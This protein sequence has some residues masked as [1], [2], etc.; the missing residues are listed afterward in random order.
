MEILITGG[1]GF[2]GINMVRHLLKKGHN[3]TS[4]DIADFDYPE[5]SKIIEIKGDVRDRDVVK[6]STRKILIW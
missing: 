5:K 2:L 4:L 6:K 3:V 1:A